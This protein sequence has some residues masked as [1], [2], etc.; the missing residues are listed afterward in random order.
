[1]PKRKREHLTC[2]LCFESIVAQSSRMTVKDLQHALQTHNAD[3]GPAPKKTLIQRMRDSVKTLACGHT[4]HTE[5]LRSMVLVGRHQER[6]HCP[7]CRMCVQVPK[8][9]E[10]VPACVKC[11]ATRNTP[12]F[13][14]ASCG[15]TIHVVCALGAESVHCCRCGQVSKQSFLEK[16][17]V[18]AI[19][20]DAWLFATH[21]IL[22]RTF[23]D[24]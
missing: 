24:V 1:M 5:C 21:E 14:L 13:I 17:V 2:T 6:M 4:F 10:D 11:C 12:P 23:Y 18:D 20:D 7:M 8:V 16:A 22:D 15:H 3:S 9:T 19:R